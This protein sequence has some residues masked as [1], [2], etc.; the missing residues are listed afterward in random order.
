MSLAGQASGQA[1]ARIAIR[2]ALQSP[3]PG[4]ARKAASVGSTGAARCSSSRP[5][6]T[7]RASACSAAT[8]WRTM[9]RVPMDSAVVSAS[10]WACGNKRSRPGK[11]VSTG[12]PKRATR[13]A[14]SVRAA[15]TVTCCP[16]ITRT[17]LS[18]PSQPLGR[19]TPATGGPGSG[20]PAPSTAS[21]R[22]GSASRSS[23]WRVRA[24]R[25][26]AAGISAGARRRA[27]SQRAGTKRA[28]S[29]PSSHWPWC[30][31]ASVRRMARPSTCSTPGS[32]RSRWK[33]STPAR[34]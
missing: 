28:S 10:V 11:G 20:G 14:L 33:A 19:R 4:S 16:R 22:S 8:R 32:A 21:M 27:S 30:C 23:A 12:R 34:S 26:P 17:A 1:S 24:I 31:T 2:W 9:P 25:L 29:Q 6:A 13:R 5:L 15:A 3:M 7:S 18:K